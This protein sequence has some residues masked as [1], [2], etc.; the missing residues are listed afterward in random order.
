MTM[1]DF[2]ALIDRN[3]MSC[4]KITEEPFISRQGCKLEWSL[5]SN[6]HTQSCVT[7]DTWQELFDV[8]PDLIKRKPT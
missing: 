1:D 6:W 7:A 2:S 3:Q 4:F 5:R 8:L